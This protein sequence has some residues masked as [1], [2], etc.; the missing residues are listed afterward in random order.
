LRPKEIEAGK[1]QCAKCQ[2]SV[3]AAL[4][5]GLRKQGGKGEQAKAED[6]HPGKAIYPL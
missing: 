6:D 1:H 4:H 2:K 3:S 5:G